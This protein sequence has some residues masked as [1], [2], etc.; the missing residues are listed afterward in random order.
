MHCIGLQPLKP[1]LLLGNRIVE[2][3]L[4]QRFV[5]TGGKARYGRVLRRRRFSAE[6]IGLAL[7]KPAAALPVA[8]SVQGALSGFFLDDAGKQNGEAFEVD[9]FENPGVEAAVDV[10]LAVFL[11]EG[12]GDGEDGH[13]AVERRAG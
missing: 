8:R 9:G 10:E 5:R 13:A 7:L 2:R 4:R 12:G 3:I 6:D 11:E 1:V